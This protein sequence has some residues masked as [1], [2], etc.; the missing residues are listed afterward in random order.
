M[1]DVTAFRYGR[2][3]DLFDANSNNV[4]GSDDMAALATGIVQA[5]NLATDSPKSQAIH[6]AYQRLWEVLR[7]YADADSD[8]TITRDEFIQA[9]SNAL[10]SK[11]QFAQSIADAANAEFSV[12]DANDDGRIDLAELQATLESVG[13]TKEE[14]CQSAANIDTDGDGVISRGEYQAAWVRYYL[15]GDPE[16]DMYL[17]GLK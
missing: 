13:L 3:F 7:Q 5:G 2:T 12:I 15:E 9:M 4:I 6:A 8:G 17:G 16:V 10:V 11:V 1:S 14:A